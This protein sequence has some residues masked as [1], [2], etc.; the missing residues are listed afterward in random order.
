MTRYG[1]L[2]EADY[3]IGC[4]ICLK[5]C[6]DEFEGNDYPPYSAA[7]PAAS[8]GYGPDATFGWPDTPAKLTAWYTTGQLWMNVK[9]QIVG[10]YPALK[11]RY[12]PIPCMHC[13]SAPCQKASSGGAVSTRSDG[14][15]LIDPVKSVGQSRLVASCPYS[16]V[17]WN[18]SSN[19]PQKCTFC[20]HLVDQ[21]KSPRCVEACPVSVMTFGDL[22]DPTS[23]IS[24]K[25][26]TLKAEPL[27]PEYAT[28]PKVYY[29]GLAKPF[30]KGTVV[31]SKGGAGLS[32]AAVQLS[33]QDGRTWS[34][35]TNFYGD[36]E[37]SNLNAGQMYSLQVTMTG[38]M[39]KKL[40]V[41]LD[42]PKHIGKVPL[43]AVV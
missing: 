25:I 20:A 4:D 28:M 12:L 37:F 10:R 41:F 9:E 15:V 3:C 32:G 26:K 29:S 18:P 40:V 17:F 42:V 43:S 36:F 23:T 5:A 13:E 1:M 31:D 2:I 39:I 16:A 30:L 27:H 35:N 34:G 21:G 24:K 19:M 7:Q 33:A 8:Y 38:K 22:D 11:A 6:K 14:I